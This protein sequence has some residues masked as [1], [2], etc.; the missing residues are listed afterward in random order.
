MHANIRIKITIL[1][2]RFKD[3]FDCEAKGID[4]KVMA[5]WWDREWRLVIVATLLP[6]LLVSIIS[7]FLVP[8]TSLTESLFYG[9]VSS[10]FVLL[11]FRI[12]QHIEWWGLR[13][14]ILVTVGVAL[15]SLLSIFMFR[16]GILGVVGA[17]M[18]SILLIFVFR[19]WKH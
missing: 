18:L 11:A 7:A 10:L 15:F 14:V 13:F 8:E 19:I 2:F 17:V 5:K 12:L 6:I 16:I 4:G 1:I 9:A 3:T